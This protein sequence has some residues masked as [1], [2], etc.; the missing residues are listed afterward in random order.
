MAKLYGGRQTFGDPNVVRAQSMGPWSLILKKTNP[1]RW[2]HWACSLQGALDTMLSGWEFYQHYSPFK[3]KREQEFPPWKMWL[4]T[5]CRQRKLGLWGQH[6]AVALWERKVEGYECR[7]CGQRAFSKDW[8][9][10]ATGCCNKKG[11]KKLRNKFI[12]HDSTRFHK[13]RLYST[14]WT[15]IPHWHIIEFHIIPHPIVLFHIHVC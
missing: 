14:K 6:A 1:S 5:R 12:P 4:T 3:K 7:G 11:P 2:V 10:A 8:R 9:R 15:W 13:T